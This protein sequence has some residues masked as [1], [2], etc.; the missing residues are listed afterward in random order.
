MEMDFNSDLNV[1]LQKKTFRKAGVPLI[2][3]SGMPQVRVGVIGWAMQLIGNHTHFYA[4]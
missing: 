1:L 4:I 3:M 2:V